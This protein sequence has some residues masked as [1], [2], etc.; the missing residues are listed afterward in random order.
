MSNFIF[1]IAV[2]FYRGD[3]YSAM[4][5]DNKNKIIFAHSKQRYV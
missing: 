4:F 3:F 1:L 2:I 5:F